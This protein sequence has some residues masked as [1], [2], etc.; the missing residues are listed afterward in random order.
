MNSK[1]GLTLSE[2]LILV[3]IFCI[4]AAIAGPRFSRAQSEA[5]LTD[6]VSDLQTVRSQIELYRIQHDDMLPGQK[7]RGGDIL[8][9][10]FVADMTTASAGGL[11]PYL[12]EIPVNS[13]NGLSSITCVNQRDAR[14]NG[15]EGTGWWLNAATGMFHAGDST[16]HAEY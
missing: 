7:E 2:N 11:G 3:G 14:P 15:Q 1:H 16:F 5:R 6:M 8:E 12:K 13:F 4:V 9:E 10:D